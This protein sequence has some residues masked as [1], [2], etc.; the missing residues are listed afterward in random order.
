MD[1]ED[2]GRNL[3][4]MRDTTPD[5]GVADESIWRVD[6]GPSVAEKFARAKVIWQRAERER[7]PGWQ[8][9]YRR[10][11]SGMFLA[12]ENCTATIQA[13]PQVMAD[14]NKPEDVK[15]E[16]EDHV[17][18]MLRYACMS[19]PWKKKT[20]P[21]TESLIKPLTF[22]DIMKSNRVKRSYERRI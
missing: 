11:D 17:A 3:L 18:D 13:I 20:A 5:Y 7:I 22:N 8:E 2:V 10:I 19:R 6:S 1:A 4:A 16:G 12:M 14:E 9:L 15:K 21:K